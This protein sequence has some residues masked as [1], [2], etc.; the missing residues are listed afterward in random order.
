MEELWT[1]YC[2]GQFYEVSNRFMSMPSLRN[3]IIGLQLYKYKIYGLLHW[4]Y[5]FYNSSLSTEKLNPYQ[6]TDAKGSF[7]SG[8]AFLVY[9]GPSGQPEESIRLMVLNQALQDMRALSLL[10]DLTS[11]EE[12]LD[13]IDGNLAQPLTLKTYPKSDMY[14]INLREQVNQKIKLEVDRI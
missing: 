1:Y 5:N 4:G 6:V 7:P 13:L 10:E 11:R 2:V 9:P 12:V 3:R 8:D 14:L